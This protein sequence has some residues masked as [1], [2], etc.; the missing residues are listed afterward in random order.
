MGFKA[1]SVVLR[2]K[3][4]LWRLERHITSIVF[5]FWAVFGSLNVSLFKNSAD[6]YQISLQTV[7]C[8]LA[9]WIRYLGNSRGKRRGSMRKAYRKSNSS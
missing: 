5:P 3:G 1:F 4:F 7:I 8:F 6:R 9:W 2:P